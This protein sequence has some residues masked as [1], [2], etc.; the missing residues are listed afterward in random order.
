MEV[1]RSEEL[2]NLHLTSSM[3][4]VINIFVVEGIRDALSG[5]LSWGRCCNLGGGGGANP[6]PI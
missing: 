6:I 2:K 1:C 3:M 4:V 5:V